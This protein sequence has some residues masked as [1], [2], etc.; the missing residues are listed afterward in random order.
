MIDARGGRI[1]AVA[2]MDGYGTA[3]ATGPPWTEPWKGGKRGVP[4]ASNDQNA[5]RILV[6]DPE[7]QVRRLLRIG[8]NSQGYQMLEATT[9]VRGVELAATKSSDL[10]VLDPDLPDMDGFTVLGEIRS[11]SK[12][13]ILVL[14]ACS[15]ENEKVRMFDAGA[16]DYVTKPFGPAEFLARVRNLLRGT[17]ANGDGGSAYDDGYLTIDLAYRR[18]AV[19]DRYVRL[20]RKEFDVLKVL[21]THRG[22]VVTQP[23]LLSQVWGPGHRD[24]THYLRVIVG[25]LRHKL[26][27]DPARPRYLFTEPGIGYR[28]VTEAADAGSKQPDC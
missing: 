2:G 1:E 20:T 18:I 21:F 19:E 9:G 11:W 5:S 15:D 14:S 27:D 24:Q 23:H 4:M 6:I 3:A 8:L 25:R 28:M 22:R 17:T 26:G 10:V 12:V 16:N 7:V 13:P